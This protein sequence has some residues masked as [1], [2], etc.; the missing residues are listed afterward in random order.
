MFCSLAAVCGPDRVASLDLAQGPADACSVSFSPRILHQE[1]FCW[2][3]KQAQ[4]IKDLINSTA[5]LPQYCCLFVGAYL[6]VPAGRI[7]LPCQA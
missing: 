6:R 5:L 3:C 2:L 7:V 4:R 1:A